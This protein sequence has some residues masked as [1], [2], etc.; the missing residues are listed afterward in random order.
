MKVKNNSDSRRI[1]YI[2]ALAAFGCMALAQG[3]SAKESEPEELP[4]IDDSAYI[5]EE[6]DCTELGIERPSG[7]CAAGGNIYICDYDMGTIAVF[8]REMNFQ[9]TIGE[10]GMGEGEFMEPMDV[11]VTDDHIYVLDT[12]NSR[13]QILTPDGEYEDEIE[14]TPVP[15]GL[16]MFNYYSLAVDENGNI[17]VSTN[18]SDKAVSRTWR[19]LRRKQC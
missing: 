19:P 14:L 13:V 18:M 10:L 1:N 5:V 6:Y 2:L 8:D 16:D 7:L 3:V 17:C 11:E 4:P 9:K 15:I 12:G